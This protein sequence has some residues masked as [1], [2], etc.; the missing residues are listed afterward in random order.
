MFLSQY[1]HNL[2]EKGRLTIPAR[3]RE[4]LVDGAYVCQGFDRNLMVLTT[5]FFNLISR[6]VNQMSITDPGAR[7]LRRLIFSTAERLEVDRA[8]RILIPQYLRELAQL[9]G[10]AIVVGVGSHFEVWSP[11]TW[12]EQLNLLQDAEAN[13]QRFAA[14]DLSAEQP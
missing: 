9:D 14:F 5:P 1:R 13:A 12:D 3:Y 8:G 6:R 10:E 11:A 4:L 2:D 7:Q